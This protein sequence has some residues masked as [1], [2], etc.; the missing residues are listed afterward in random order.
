MKFGR[1]IQCIVLTAGKNYEWWLK[2]NAMDIDDETCFESIASCREVR[3][4]TATII[5]DGDPNPE[6]EII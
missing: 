3:E 5:P 4:D 2:E 6:I 1:L